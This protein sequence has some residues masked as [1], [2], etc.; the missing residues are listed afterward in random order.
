VGAD[1]FGLFYTEFFFVTQRITFFH[2]ESEKEITKHKQP[3]QLPAGRRSPVY[4]PVDMLLIR[5][6]GPVD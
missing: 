3:S 6:A 5:R 1:G 2:Q 4:I